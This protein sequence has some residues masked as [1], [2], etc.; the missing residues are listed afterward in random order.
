MH[1]AHR[2]SLHPLSPYFSGSSIVVPCSNQ[3][4][5]MQACTLSRFSHVRLCDPVDC[6]LSDSSDHGILPARI[7]EWV[8]I[9][10]STGSSWA[11]DRTHLYCVFC[12]AS[13]FFTAEPPGKPKQVTWDFSSAVIFFCVSIHIIFIYLFCN[14]FSSYLF[15]YKGKSCI[16]S[17]KKSRVAPKATVITNSQVTSAGKPLSSN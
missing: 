8:A 7:L 14:Q 11:G 3:M 16:C 12:I 1:E 2:P 17:R 15:S 9:P 10:F 13:R 5:D 4:S 6:S